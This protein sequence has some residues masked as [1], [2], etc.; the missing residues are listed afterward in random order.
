MRGGEHQLARDDGG[1]SVEDERGWAGDETYSGQAAA[2]LEKLSYAV[3]YGEQ[4]HNDRNLT[5][6]RENL[7][8]MDRGSAGRG[9][10]GRGRA[11]FEDHDGHTEGWHDDGD[12]DEPRGF[13][14]RPKFRDRP[15]EK[16]KK[17]KKKKQEESDEEEPEAPCPRPS[18]NP[19][20]T[21]P[22]P[23]API[24]PKWPHPA[25]PR[26]IFWSVSIRALRT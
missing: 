15:I 8:A 23:E 10:S 11:S 3:G 18:R 22:A 2:A 16:K 1:F 25:F 26:R 5:G 9:I 12:Y 19:N 20:W 4:T 21:H 24:H 6:S 7:A 13:G 14:A 17:K